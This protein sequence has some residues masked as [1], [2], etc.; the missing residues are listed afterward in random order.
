VHTYLERVWV[1]RFLTVAKDPLLG[2]RWLLRGLV[3]FARHYFAR[4]LSYVLDS[5]CALVKI[6]KVVSLGMGRVLLEIIF[7]SV[8]LDQLFVAHK[9]FGR[10]PSI[11]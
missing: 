3:F 11:S 5:D 9:R 10:N 7:S 4:L 8:Y 1:D 2:V 6:W